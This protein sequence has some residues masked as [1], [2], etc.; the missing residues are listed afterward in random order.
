MEAMRMRRWPTLATI[1]AVV[2]LLGA[3]CSNNDETPSATAASTTATTGT[4]TSG[5]QT[6]GTATSGTETS[7]GGEGGQITINGDT[8]NDHGS[9]DVSGMDELELEADDFYFEPT[10]L[11]GTA[12]ETLKLELRNEGGTEHNFTLEDQNID[13]DIEEGEDATVT[14]TFPD[15]GVLEFYCKY[16]RSSGMVGQ[17]SVG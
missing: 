15:S 5:T 9:K 14:V 17:L 7:G 4:A 8:A 10:T 2:A 1:L 3:A 13:Q 11:N 12:G 6:S 16:H